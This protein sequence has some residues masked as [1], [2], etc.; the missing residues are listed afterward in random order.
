MKVNIYYGGRGFIE[1]PTLY[2]INKLTEVLTELRVTVNRYNLYEEKNQIAMLAKTLKEADGVILA[3]TIEWYGVGGYMQQF[4]DAC[5]MYGDKEYL[6]NLYMLPV[7]MSTA[8]WE[9]E[10]ELF[11]TKAWEMLGGIPCTGLKAYVEDHVEFETNS[12]YAFMIE[13]QAETFY[14]TINQKSKMLPTSNNIIRNNILRGNSNNLTPQENEQL[15]M[16]VSDDTYVKKQKEDI[17]ELAQI[18]KGMLGSGQGDKEEELL[19]RL[20]AKFDPSNDKDVSFSIAFNETGKNLI[21]EVISKKLNCY[22]GE[23]E[24]ADTYI[25][26]SF[27]TIKK[28]TEGVT[29]MQK[30]FMS[31]D[32]TAKGNFN[33]LRIFDQI[34]PFA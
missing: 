13:K 20:R 12:T 7:V 33:T 25:K 9:R 10:G 16:Y 22:F 17:E 23:R 3:T 18:F 1:D 26:A 4:L 2:V 8:C 11:L 15:S 28:I 27:Q 6:S 21:I 5:W 24:N 19:P 34:F 14:K 32:L 31:G 30:A 29:T